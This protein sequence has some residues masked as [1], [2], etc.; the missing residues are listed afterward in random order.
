MYAF[1]T[2]YTSS[3][4]YQANSLTFEKLGASGQVNFITPSTLTIFKSDSTGLVTLNSSGQL[5]VGIGTSFSPLA[6][7]EGRAT[8]GA[9]LAASYDA[10]NSLTVTVSS[11]GLA[12]FTGAGTSKGLVFT[13]GIQAGTGAGRAKVC[14]TLKTISTTSANSGSAETDLHS[15]TL[16]GNTLAADGDSIRSTMTWKTFGNSNL[17][18]IKV[19]FG[20][21]TVVDSSTGT[22]NLVWLTVIVTITRKSATTQVAS[23]IFMPSIGTGWSSP[24]GGE[25]DCSETLSGSVILKATGQGTST[26]DVTQIQTIVEYLPANP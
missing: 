3:G 17:K 4:R 18:T 6:K 24:Y 19:K 16:L 11:A 12:T 1:N 25:V 10:S 26:N 20:A 2:T 14:G 5:G 22:A 7:I 21:T 8:S 9:Q 23:F 15:F 13:D